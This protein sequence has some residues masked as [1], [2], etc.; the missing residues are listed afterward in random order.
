MVAANLICFGLT[1]F[2]SSKFSYWTLSNSC[3]VGPALY[4]VKSAGAVRAS[5][6]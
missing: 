3:V 4:G 2:S 1:M 6:V 5:E